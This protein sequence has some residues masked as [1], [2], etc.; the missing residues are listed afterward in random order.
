MEDKIKEIKLSKE[1]Y[2][3]LNEN[4]LYE[5]KPIIDN[6]FS[7]GTISGTY[8]CRNWTFRMFKKD[9]RVFSSDTYFNYRYEEITDEN[10]NDYEKV[11]D[12]RE[13]ERVNDDSFGEYDREDLF[14]VATNSGGYTCG[15]LWWKKK[16]TKKNKLLVI[17]KKEEK[18]KKAERDIV[19]YKGE[20][21]R[22][23]N[24]EWYEEFK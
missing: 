16:S 4:F 8:H 24:N 1:N 6:S 13:V 18:I 20:I 9:G 2:E 17:H 5:K 15:N 11:F 12:F 3:K 22:I 7:V 23:E 14:Y 10:I 21:K 19:F